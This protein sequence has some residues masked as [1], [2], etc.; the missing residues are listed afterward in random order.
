MAPQRPPMTSKRLALILVSLVVL[1]VLTYRQLVHERPPVPKTQRFRFTGP[2]MGTTYIVKVV[3]TDDYSDALNTELAHRISDA[4]E[5]VNALMSTYQ[6]DS[7]LSRFNASRS[8][9]PFSIS[10]ET[11]EVF[12]CAQAV[13]RA[14]NGALDVTIGPLVNAWGFGPEVRSGVPGD[15]EIDALRKRVGYEKLV[16]D[17]DNNTIRK[18]IPDLYCD[19][20][21][22]AKG[23][24][25]DRVA[26]LLEAMGLDYFVEVG[27]EVRAR[28]VDDAGRPL[29]TAGIEQPIPDRRVVYRVVPMAE[30]ALATSG[31]YRNFYEENG[32]RISHTIDPRT[33]RPVRHPPGSVSVLDARCAVADAYATALVVLGPEAG[34]ALA[35]ELDLPALFLTVDEHGTI[36]ERMTPAFEAIVTGPHANVGSKAL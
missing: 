11:A 3:P 1:S 36:Q 2:T 34:Y 25:V 33:G 32:E 22:V 28:G 15:A 29:W 17:L 35:V 31:G 14:T 16:L 24:A 8:L 27:G 5:N 21:A 20:S 26:E 10:K 13:S 30:G 4:L 6:P 19:L 23:Y 9:E 12:A 7:E 18:T